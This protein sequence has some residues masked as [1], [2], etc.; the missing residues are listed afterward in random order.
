M[1]DVEE[2]ILFAE[3]F[4]IFRCPSCE[5]YVISSYGNNHCMLSGTSFGYDTTPDW[6]PL[7]KRDTPAPTPEKEASCSKAMTSDSTSSV[8][9]ASS[10]YSHS[11]CLPSDPTPDAVEAALDY[12]AYDCD[13]GS[14]H[15]ALSILRAEIERLRAEN[16]MLVSE[17]QMLTLQL[18]GTDL[19]PVETYMTSSTEC[20]H[21]WT[22]MFEDTA[23]KH[24]RCHYCGVQRD[25]PMGYLL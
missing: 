16:A 7:A 23:G 8:E 11:C 25:T 1:D 22:L 13:N 17:K 2:A 14:I 3:G 19:P 4:K 15:A 21:S 18:A 24:Y 5:H 20:Q 12:L 9:P 10:P 6:C